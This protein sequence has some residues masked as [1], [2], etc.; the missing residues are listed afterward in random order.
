MFFCV[1][2]VV[3]YLTLTLKEIAIKP[4]A[5]V[6]LKLGPDLDAN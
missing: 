1:F 4:R 3:N 2:A 5:K 6:S